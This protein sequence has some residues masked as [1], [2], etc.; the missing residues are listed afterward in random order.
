MVSRRTI[1][2]GIGAAVLLSC[3]SAFADEAQPFTAEA[4]RAAQDSGKP[5]LVEI[6]ASWC[7]TCAAQKPILSDLV[8]DPKFKDMTVLRVDFDTQKKEVRGFHAQV[9]S[10]LIVFK[11]T[12]EVARSVGETTRDA[13]AALLDKAI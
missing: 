1:L 9:Q 3:S 11:G 7:T 10:T 12:K 5:I 6:H 8:A 4:F 2:A 13:I